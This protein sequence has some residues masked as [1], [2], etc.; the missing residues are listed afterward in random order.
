LFPHLREAKNLPHQVISSPLGPE[1]VAGRIW[2]EIMIS[3]E[4]PMPIGVASLREISVRTMKRSVF[5]VPLM[6]RPG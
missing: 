5:R 1:A 2:M 4:L 3:V 6:A